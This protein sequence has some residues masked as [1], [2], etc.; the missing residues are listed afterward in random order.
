VVLLCRATFLTAAAANQSHSLR[1]GAV[2][3]QVSQRCSPCARVTYSCG[4]LRQRSLKAVSPA[5]IKAIV[6]LAPMLSAE[7]WGAFAGAEVQHSGASVSS[8]S[9]TKASSA[10]AAR[11]HRAC[12]SVVF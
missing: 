10:R 3:V 7:S 9:R 12:A 5:S 2:F 1:L 4:S 11:F 8:S 6:C